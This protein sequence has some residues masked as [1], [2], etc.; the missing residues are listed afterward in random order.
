MIIAFTWNYRLNTCV[1]NFALDEANVVCL[2]LGVDGGSMLQCLLTCDL[3][4]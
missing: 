3:S 4:L 1:E 2:C